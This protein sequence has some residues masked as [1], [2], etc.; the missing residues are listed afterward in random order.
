MAAALS[1]SQR[2]AFVA[3]CL[4]MR[5]GIMDVIEPSGQ[6][7]IL[8]E[9]ADAIAEM[10]HGFILVIHA[11]VTSK[12]GSVKLSHDVLPVSIS[13]MIEEISHHCVASQGEMHRLE[14]IDGYTSSA[15]E[16][17][18]MI[19]RSYAVSGA[20]PFRNL[21]GFAY[22]AFELCSKPGK[23]RFC[24]REDLLDDVVFLF[25]ERRL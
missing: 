15:E 21:R 25:G 11:A 16:I 22:C 3:L 4:N 10:D 17:Q 20:L 2:C 6:N 12:I 7:M 9:I 19:Y 13:L 23:L 8:Q 24:R 14:F 5:K 18:E 1:S